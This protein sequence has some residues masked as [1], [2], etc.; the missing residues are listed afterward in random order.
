[1]CK[2]HKT[3][4]A[5]GNVFFHNKRDGSK[6]P[7][8]IRLFEFPFYY[9]TVTFLAQKVAFKIID[10]SL[11]LVIFRGETASY[12]LCLASMCG[13]WIKETSHREPHLIFWIL[14]I[15]TF[16]V[17]FSPSA[18]RRPHLSQC[19]SFRPNTYSTG[20]MCYHKNWFPGVSLALRCAVEQIESCAGCQAHMMWVPSMW[21]PEQAQHWPSI[22][23]ICR[24]HPFLS[25]SS[26]CILSPPQS[27][28]T[29]Q[30]PSCPHIFFTH[31]LSKHSGD[32]IYLFFFTLLPLLSGCS[33][34][35]WHIE[36]RGVSAAAAAAE[37]DH[38]KTKQLSF[39]TDNNIQ[40][41]VMMWDHFTNILNV[42]K[43][44]RCLWSASVPPGS[45]LICLL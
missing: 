35:M 19:H 45:F 38:Y 44:V 13:S 39:V 11:F 14:S 9:P 42:T 15:V 5:N 21:G 18:V 36:L 17:K 37:H 23:S 20:E 6:V 30:V 16:N 33:V 27:S 34:F 43:A 29:L 40:S 7:I 22:F 4:K 28:E 3:I 2:K 32:P 25:L 1:M 12:L 24:N 10:F 8:H 31:W 26:P 41:C